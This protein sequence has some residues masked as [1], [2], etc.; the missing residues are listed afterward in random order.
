MMPSKKFLLTAAFT[1]AISFSAAADPAGGNAAET[2]NYRLKWLYNASVIGDIYALDRGLFEKNG[3]KVDVKEG[4][5]ERDAIR[6]L[7]LG[8]A[9]FGAA[10]ADQV[11]RALEKKSPVVVIAQLFQV[12]PL[13]WIYRSQNMRI[14]AL[15]DL[16]GKRIGVTFGGNDDNV[17][18][19]LLAKSRLKEG[20]YTLYSVRYDLTPFYQKKADIWP[21]YINTQG[22]ILKKK[23]ENEGE[24][25]SFL[26][27]ADYGVKFVANSVVTSVD[28]LK[29]H[30]DIV[31]KFI[32]ALMAGWRE[33]LDPANERNAMETLKKFEKGTAVD[34]QNA[35]LAAT[36]PLIKPKQETK[37]GAIDFDAWKQTEQIMLVQKQIATPVNVEKALKPLPEA[38]R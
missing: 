21:C 35:Q 12:N 4:G 9:H 14:D 11:I 6:E 23:L 31:K 16:K 3:L 30:P 2:F 29:N 10:S 22:V 25:V 38:Y 1:I 33:S 32:D 36:R 28:M 24:S 17:M 7:E 5:P 37:I 8:H 34:V 26:N 13:H 18:K 15:S 19:T 20:D 27:P